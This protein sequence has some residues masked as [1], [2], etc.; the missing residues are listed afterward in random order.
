MHIVSLPQAIT[1]GTIP[2]FVDVVLNFDTKSLQD[3]NIITQVGFYFCFGKNNAE[4][5]NHLSNV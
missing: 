3:D 4:V 2:G 5:L 1:S